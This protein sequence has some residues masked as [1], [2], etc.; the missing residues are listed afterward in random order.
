MQNIAPKNLIINPVEFDVAAPFVG[1]PEH[2]LPRTLLIIDPIPRHVR[3][4]ECLR[5]PLWVRHHRQMSTVVRA[6]SGQTFDASVG[7]HGVG[8]GGVSGIVHIT[9]S[10]TALFN[11]LLVDGVVFERESAFTVGNPNSENG[12]FHALQHDAFAFFDF[13]GAPSALESFG[14]VVFQ[15]DVRFVVSFYRTVAHPSDKCHQL[16]TVANAQTESVWSCE[17]LFE[18]L[19]HTFVEEDTGGPSF[20]RS[21]HV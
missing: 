6:D 7:I 17:E 1:V 5:A 14:Q 11:K 2:L 19:T 10:H 20:G 9:K 4:L 13:H 15:H 8:F 18:L 12:V 3:P 16:A 21:Q